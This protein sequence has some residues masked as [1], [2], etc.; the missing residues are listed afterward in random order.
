[1]GRAPGRGAPLRT[2]APARLCV[3]PVQQ[4]AAGQQ[5]AGGPPVVVTTPGVGYRIVDPDVPAH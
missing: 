2:P 1:M 4:Y 3:A 5:R